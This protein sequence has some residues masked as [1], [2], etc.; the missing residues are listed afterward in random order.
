MNALLNIPGRMPGLND[1]SDA[2]RKHRQLAAKMKAAETNLVA[3][4]AR[5]LPVFHHPIHLTI[6]YREPNRKRDK[7]NIAFAKKFILD[8]LVMAG[9]IPN[10][11]WAWIDG[12]SESFVV[13]TKDPGIS[14]MIKE[15]KEFD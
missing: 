9:K 2:E 12:W 10:D 7:D 13:D 11:T 5:S 4:C 8:G 15:V 6:V 14:V 1:Y 3:L